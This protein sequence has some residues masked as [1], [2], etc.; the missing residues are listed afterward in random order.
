MPGIDEKNETE[1]DEMEQESPGSERSEDDEESDTP[2][3]SDDEESSGLLSLVVGALAVYTFDLEYLILSP[4]ENC[5]EYN[6]V[7]QRLNYMVTTISG[8]S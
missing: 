7:G 6:T 3:G 2:S 1:D 5:Q 4:T 8:F